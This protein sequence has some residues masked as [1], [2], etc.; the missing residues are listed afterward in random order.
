[1]K[2][3]T[4]AWFAL[5]TCDGQSQLAQK[6]CPLDYVPIFIAPFQ[7]INTVSSAAQ[8]QLAFRGRRT[9]LLTETVSHANKLIII[10]KR[11]LR[12]CTGSIH[13]FTV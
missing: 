10:D 6:R 5:Q 11:S 13:T 8:S 1:M 9:E 3:G 7:W 2:R 4:W 12:V